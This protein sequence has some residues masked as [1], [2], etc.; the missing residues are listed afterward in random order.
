M[1]S[2]FRKKITSFF[3]LFILGLAVLALVFTDFGSGMGGLGAL[4]GGGSSP[5]LVEVEGRRITENDLT[6][7]ANQ[8]YRRALQQQP[9]LDMQTFLAGDTFE[10]LLTSMVVVAALSEFADDQ[11]MVVSRQAIDRTIVGLPDFRNLAGDFDENLFRQLLARQNLTEGQVRE[12]IRLS[13]MRRQL[14]AP[15]A[16]GAHVPETVAREYANLLLERRRGTIGVVPAELLARGIE[17]SEAEVAAFYQANR[18][19]FTVPEQ[20][21]VQYA[22]FGPEQVAAAARATEQEVQAYYRQNQAQYAG[23]ERRTLQHLVLPTEAQ[24]QQAAQRLRAGAAFAEVASG[25]GFAAADLTYENQAQSDFAGQTAPEVAQAAFRAEQGSVVGPVRAQGLFHV[26]RV[27][28][29]A[30]T[31]ARPLETVRGEI[32]AAIEERKLADA[33]GD[34]VDRIDDRLNQG[35]NV[36]EIAQ[37]ERLTVT[38]TPPVDA[39][40][41]ARGQDWQ[42]PAELRALLPSAFELDSDSPEPVVEQLPDG[43]RFALVGVERVIPAAVPPLARIRDQVRSALVAQRAQERARSVA[44][45]IVQRINGG[46]PAGRAFAEAGVAGLPTPQSVNLQRL[47]ISRAGA[48]VPPPLLTLFSLPQGRAQLLAA[49]N[50]AGWFVVH[51]EQRTPGDASGN[52]ALIASTRTEFTRSLGEELAQQFA[53]A[54]EMRAEVERDE[55]AIRQAR[56]RLVGAAE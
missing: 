54:I 7:R 32:A 45:G 47:E 35:A 16:G 53:R 31:Q 52:A 8:E 10:Q 44:Q 29:V 25:L 22:V 50:G 17:P 27:E 9:T 3:V 30:R 20:R 26:V 12:D 21:V 56:Q 19:R 15:V 14:L 2:T 23:Q 40:G 6:Q 33:L 39:A 36:R 24:A 34:L 48:D 5:T 51:H 13:L 49:P 42:P 18:A 37:A 46:M 55:E 41:R 11:G 43:Q 28:A 38:A 1:L 4:S